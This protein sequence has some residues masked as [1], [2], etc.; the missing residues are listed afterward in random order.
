MDRLDSALR[1]YFGFEQF[2]SGQREVIERI[3]S[4]QHTLAVL[5]TGLGKSLCYQLA[6]QLLPGVTLVISPL[7]ALMQDQ[8]ESL[9]RRGFKN[10]TFL[11]SALAPAQVGARYNQIEQGRYKL[12][13]VA[14]ERCDSPRFQKL[15]REAG[16]NL[17]V[18]DEAHCISQW[19]H[20]FRPHYRLLLTR[21][22]ELRHSTLLALTATATPTVQND[23]ANALCQ[24]QIGRVIVD[25]N[26][27]NLRFESIRVDKRGEKDARLMELLA[28]KEE[29]AI[30]YASTR[31]EAQYAHDLLRSR[32]FDAGLYH[33]GLPPPQRAATHCRFQEGS[34]RL[35][36]ATVAFGLGIDRPDIRRVVHYNIPGSLESYYQEAGRAGRDRC[37]AICSLLYSQQDLRVQR[38]MIDNSYPAPSIVFQLYGR[39][40]K[41]H[42]L[43]VSVD[44]LATASELPPITVSA[45]LQILYEQ[46]WLNMTPDGKYQI[47]RFEQTRPQV[48]FRDVG[49]RRKRANER[50]KKMI[51]YAAGNQC[52]RA[53]ILDY[54]GQRFAPPCE[55]CDV[56]APTDVARSAP[57]AVEA[58]A[59]EESDRVARIILQTVAS[60]RG[61]LGRSLIAGVL[62]GSKRRQIIELALDKSQNYGALSLHSRDRVMGWIDELVGQMLLAV[63]AEE[64]PRLLVTEAGRCALNTTALLQLSGVI[65]SA[66]TCRRFGVKRSDSER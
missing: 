23:I 7:I 45:A 16:V 32:G 63:T 61:R 42:P 64:F 6:A 56:C 51:A 18:I 30:V 44:D 13:Y 2:R 33:A 62:S 40:R 11:S 36:V 1:R 29:S 46:Q 54:F 43:P 10:V 59:N 25:F 31:R 27:P 66:A 26:R 48:N 8:V 37:P 15:V 41:A 21:L 49:L 20:D 28:N 3:L 57:R 9:L 55:A 38:F 5:P 34:A 12:I 39:L 60:F 50:L 22:P 14:P 53:Q 4:R 65:W 17:L 24:P 47:A 52:R 35:I 58:P 19:G